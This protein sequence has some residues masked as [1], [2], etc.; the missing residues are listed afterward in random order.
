MDFGGVLVK[1][2]CAQGLRREGALTG[3][4]SDRSAGNRMVA[5]IG[6]SFPFSSLRFPYAAAPNAEWI[7]YALK[8]QERAMNMEAL[9][10][11]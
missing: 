6:S 7:A 11:G 2:Q 4:I 5:G 8:A 3:A 10:H 1:A 9:R